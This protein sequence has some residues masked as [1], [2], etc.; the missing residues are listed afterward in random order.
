MLL[1]RF[2][3]MLMNSPLKTA[4]QKRLYPPLFERIG[5]KCN[6]AGQALEIGCGQGDG[7]RI[8]LNQFRATTVDAFDLDPRMI[9]RAKRRLM[10]LKGVG[11]LWVEDA[12]RISV[13]DMSYDSVFEFGAIHHI[14]DWQMVVKEIFRVL[15]P[16]GYF[17]ATEPLKK[18]I[19]S[20]VGWKISK[21]PQENRFDYS[22]FKSALETVGFN[23][24]GSNHF[25]NAIGWYVCRKEN[26][27]NPALHI[28]GRVQRL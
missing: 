28:T 23:I 25:L 9:S 8:I 14:F 1:N 20:P 11:R 16:N 19:T 5:G 12:T 24:I 7:V 15:K 26:T 22:Q 21:H 17:Y 18:V 6:D 3:F 13:P 4:I 27:P 2:E 10:G